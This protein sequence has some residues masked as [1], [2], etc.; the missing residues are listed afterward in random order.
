[1]AGKLPKINCVNILSAAMG[2]EKSNEQKFKSKETG[3]SKSWLV[4]LRIVFWV[5]QIWNNLAAL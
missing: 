3:G 1:M 5:S 4:F 2:E